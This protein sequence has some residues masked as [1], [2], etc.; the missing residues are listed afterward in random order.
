[1]LTV[2]GG[3]AGQA[4]LVAIASRVLRVAAVA[5]MAWALAGLAWLASG[6]SGASLPVPKVVHRAAPVV[7]VSRL[8]VLNL[9]GQPP[10]AT[11]KGEAASA[12][13]TS[14]QLRLTGVLVNTDAVRSSAIVTER[15]NPTAAAK[16]YRIN[17]ALPGG[18]TLTEVYD[19]RILIKR[20]DGA[21]EV[22]RF[23]KTG[24]LDGG[25]PPVAGT[26]GSKD[27]GAG[28]RGMLDNALQAMGTAP[29]QFLQQMGLKRS[30]MGYEITA[31]TPENLRNAV[32]LQA[33]DHLLSI[34]G[35]RLGD[36]RRDR[37]VLAALKSSGAAK[38]EI[39][40][41]GQI[42]TLERKF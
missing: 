28:V 2:S 17:D 36:P 19:D 11:A 21:G 24:L 10:V 6:H 13:D 33:G 23:E 3:M 14:L 39:Q 38:V 4:Q 7:D 35:R 30:S 20:G 25:T 9:F 15:N 40:R 31:G 8:A 34:N 26:P 18:A 32:G 22:L 37:D 12:P 29:E 42:V 5:W 41:G 1:M 27:D 16:V